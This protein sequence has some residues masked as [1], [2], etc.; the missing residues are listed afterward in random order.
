MAQ[1]HKGRKFASM[2]KHPLRHQSS[3]YYSQLLACLLCNVHSTFLHSKVLHSSNFAH[4][5]KAFLQPKYDSQG[6]AAVAG[7]L[8]LP[9]ASWRKPSSTPVIL[10][11]M[12][13]AGEAGPCMV[14]AMVGW[15]DVHN[16]VA[17]LAQ[18]SH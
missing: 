2:M 1:C 3:D 15:N 10:Q 16:Q 13:A 18:Y 17:A 9:Q 5:A 14:R 6:V 11:H 7:V 4:L 8:C 12:Y